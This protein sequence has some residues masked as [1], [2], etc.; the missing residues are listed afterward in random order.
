[1]STREATEEMLSEG[2]ESLIRGLKKFPS[3]YTQIVSN[4]WEDMQSAQAPATGEVEPV[5]FTNS[6]QLKALKN[7]GCCPLWASNW[8]AEIPV[9]IHPP[10]KV[11]EG[12]MLVPEEITAGQLMAAWN[13]H[14]LYADKVGPVYD[15]LLKSSPTPPADKPEGEW[16]KCSERLPT[17][18]DEDDRGDV[19]LY[20]EGVGPILCAARNLRACPRLADPLQWKPTGLTRPAAPDMGGEK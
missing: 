8:Q 14:G 3:N 7:A 13:E 19:W 2:V 4:I 5:G 20:E 18:A 16:V 10:A 9:Y 6:E 12:W 1:M 11:P 17:E 15:L